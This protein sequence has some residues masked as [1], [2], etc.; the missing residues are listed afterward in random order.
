[1]LD[2]SQV[3]KSSN[4]TSSQEE[5]LTHEVNGKSQSTKKLSHVPC[6][7]FKQGACQAGDSCPFSHETNPSL[8]FQPCKYFQ[9]GT[10]KFGMKCAL[11]H[12]LPDGQVLNPRSG[13]K[14]S[15]SSKR[16]NH[17]YTKQKEDQ[18]RTPPSQYAYSLLK[19]SCLT[20]SCSASGCIATSPLNQTS[21]IWSLTNS[22]TSSASID[23][24]RFPRTMSGPSQSKSG[25]LHWSFSLRRSSSSAIMPLLKADFKLSETAVLDDSE[26]EFCERPLIYDDDSSNDTDNVDF[27]PDSLTDLLTPQELERRNSKPALGNPR[28][29]LINDDIQFAME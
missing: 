6:K 9:K 26:D 29:L 15:S 11:A 18:V 7:F 8:E 24:S 22:P 27:L 21:S 1:M 17:Q 4:L 28:P 10:C 5:T 23:H 13:L 14:N 25:P 2:I 20:R 3:P 19:P 12:I 16:R